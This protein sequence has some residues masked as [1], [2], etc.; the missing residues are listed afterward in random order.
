M[1]NR[2][3]LISLL[4][5]IGAINS[6]IDQPGHTAASI[7][8][9]KGQIPDKTACLITPSSLKVDIYRVDICKE[10][11]FP[12]YRSSPDYAAADCI[13]LF[14]GNGNLYRGQFK[15]GYNYKL[16]QKGKDNLKPGIYN[17]LTIIFKNSFK[18][19]GRYTSGKNTWSTGGNGRGNN[20]AILE[21]NKDKLIEF[22]SKLNNWKGK[23]NK[24]ND[25]CDNN[26]GTF[27]RC[28]INYNGYELTAIGLG[29]DFIETFGSK[30]SYLFYM[31]KL[32]SPINLKE[33]STGDVALKDYNSLEVYGNGSEVKSITIA[34]FIFEAI[35]IEE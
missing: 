18:S 16:P 8:N 19:S 29:N 11:P 24:K 12:K 28:E 15:K 4:T 35:Y 9:C 6:S 27:S 21:K 2:S 17:Y 30:T 13:T 25:Y 22:T 34:P 5:F 1:K 14:N 23:R 31:N 33:N 10:S 26:G 20:Q 7:I 32:R 3:L